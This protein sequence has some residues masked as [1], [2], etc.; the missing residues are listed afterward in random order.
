MKYSKIKKQQREVKK[1]ELDFSKAMSFKLKGKINDS[2]REKLGYCF[3]DIDD[4][5]GITILGSEIKL[6]LDTKRLVY[7]PLI[8]LKADE[9]I[10]LVLLNKGSIE[11]LCYG[12]DEVNE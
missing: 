1:M 4:D 7:K 10:I 8:K 6:Y 9:R 2:I 3:F 11:F 5:F 12:V